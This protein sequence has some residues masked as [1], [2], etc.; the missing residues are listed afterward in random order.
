MAYKQRTSTF[1]SAVPHCN[2]LYKLKDNVSR[3]RIRMRVKREL[4]KK[5]NYFIFVDIFAHECHHELQS[6][7]DNKFPRK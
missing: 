2:F 6:M 4:E 1:F 7:V 3:L 5:D